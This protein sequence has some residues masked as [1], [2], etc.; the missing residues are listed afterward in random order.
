MF[1]ANAKITLDGTDRV[2]KS[3]GS[4]KV[5]K[6]YLAGTGTHRSEFRGLVRINSVDTGVSTL[7]TLTAS[8]GIVA[9]E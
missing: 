5:R 3:M 2:I 9:F 8:D 6:T 7:N 4:D 1:Q